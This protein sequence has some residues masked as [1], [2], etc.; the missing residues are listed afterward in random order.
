LTVAWFLVEPIHDVVTATLGPNA[1]PVTL[2]IDERLF[3][4]YPWPGYLGVERLAAS[5]WSHWD[6]RKAEL[7]R[8]AKITDPAEFAR[9]SATTKYGGI[10]VFAL[11]KRPA[12]W[13]WGDVVFSPKVFDSAHWVVDSTLANNT[14]VA[15]RRPGS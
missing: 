12:G 1:R 4:Y 14:V 13:A 7:Q 8:I 2:S 9:A 11:R 5:T 15:V 10:D 3:S 6:D